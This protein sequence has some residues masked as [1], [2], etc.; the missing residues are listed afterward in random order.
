[1]ILVVIW[2]LNKAA[3]LPH[4]LRTLHDGT[5]EAARLGGKAGVRVQE[6]QRRP[7]GLVAPEAPLRASASKGV[8]LLRS[9]ASTWCVAAGRLAGAASAALG[10][11]RR[12]DAPQ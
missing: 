3:R 2:A 7:G 8:A 1:L 10:S 11:E 6:Q 4:L 9:S 5:A 12:R